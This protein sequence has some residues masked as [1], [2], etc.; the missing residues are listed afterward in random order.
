MTDAKEVRVGGARAGREE[1]LVMVPE[2]LGKQAQQRSFI[3][4]V[5]KG[6]VLSKE[7][8]PHRDRPAG[9]SPNALSPI[10]HR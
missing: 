4:G 2:D 9:S 8:I 5:S 6:W 1:R 10:S 3:V 7:N